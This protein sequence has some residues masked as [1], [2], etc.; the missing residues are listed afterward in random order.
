MSI[1]MWKAPGVVFLSQDPDDSNTGLVQS[2]GGPP[3]QTATCAAQDVSWG[4]W[5]GDPGSVL[6]EAGGA[7]GAALCPPH[8]C[9]LPA[10][11]AGLQAAAYTRHRSCSCCVG[12]IGAAAQGCAGLCA[13]RGAWWGARDSLL[14]LEVIKEMPLK[15]F[16]YPL[17]ET[18]FLHA[19]GVVYKFKIR[20]GNLQR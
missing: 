20:Y 13:V 16:T 5:R 7:G 10:V 19:G 11:P 1:L 9:G 6:W 18:R 15:P 14:P 8:S 4:H 12:L 3:S 17:P 2:W